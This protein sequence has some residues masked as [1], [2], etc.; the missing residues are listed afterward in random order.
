MLSSVI[1]PFRRPLC[2]TAI[3]MI[4][5]STSAAELELPH[6][7][8]TYDGIGELHARAVARTV[9]VA[10][11]ICAEKYGFDMPDMIRINIA[12]PAKTVRLF[13]DGVDTF[14]LSLQSEADLRMPATSRVFHL[15]GLCHEVGHLAM[16]Q[17]IKDHGWLST[18]GAEGWAHYLGSLL[19][20]EVY[21]VEGGDLWP[22]AYDYRADGVRRLDEQLARSDPSE[23]ARS[24]RLWRE[25]ARAIGLDKIP[26]LFAAWGRT[27]I[28]PADPTI[29]LKKEITTIA[30]DAPLAAWWEEAGPLLFVRREASRFPKH[31]I[32]PGKLTG[33]PRTL[34]HDDGKPAGKSSIAGSGHAVRFTVPDA[35]WYLTAVEI[36]GARY[37]TPT[38]PKENFRVWLC[39]E[40]F[41]AIAEFEIPYSKFERGEP[42]WVKLPLEATNLPPK[43]V[44]CVGFNPAATK[45][46]Y[47]HYDT[48]SGSNSLTGLP[49]AEPRG[50]SRGDWMIRVSVDQTK[51]ADAL[52]PIP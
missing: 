49:G 2:L 51:E 22:D 1:C 21:A 25:L 38:A 6:V 9:E 17:P 23:V 42:K 3:L 36:Y 26:V 19:V 35:S 37:G 11:T 33:S 18:G 7:R 48:A 32:E 47:V 46:V 15:Y 5:R 24:A 44:V 43:F 41:G 10:R 28:D 40:Q 13:N 39:D 34:T 52:S 14:S 30:P 50:F 20:D 27:K 31:Q 4:C 29:S 12:A 8:A 45:G 16:Y